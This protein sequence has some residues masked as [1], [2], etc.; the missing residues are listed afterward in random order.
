ME[1]KKIVLLASGSGSN[2]ERICE[3][4]KSLD[5]I[6]VKG[7]FCNK[8]NAFVIQRMKRLGVPTFLF[9]KLEMNQGL[10][11]EQLKQ[12]SPDLIVLAGFLLKLPTEL[13]EHFDRRIVNIHPSLLPKYGGKGMYGSFV[14]QA[15]KKNNE[16]E[17]GIT[18][19]YVDSNYDTG[20]IILQKSVPLDPNDTL[21]QIAQKVQKLEHK[22]YP[23]IIEDLLNKK[24]CKKEK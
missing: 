12:I 8:S 15:V 14:H 2:A 4:F 16:A 17:T 22:F 9:N 19:H 1:I 7:L 24:V 3:Y 11:L 13:V 10:L 23:T 6:V 21:D 5:N 18:I 20:S